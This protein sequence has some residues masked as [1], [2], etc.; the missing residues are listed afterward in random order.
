MAAGVMLCF[1]STAWGPILA[2]LFFGF[3][4]CM[5]TVAPPVMVVKEFGKKDLGMVVGIV[6]AFEM[7]GAATGNV[8]SGV[9]FDTYLSFIPVWISVIVA[10]ALMGLTLI[11][12][13]GGARRLVARC[14]EQGAAALDAEGNEI[15]A[16]GGPVESAGA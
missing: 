11:A 1:A 7:L 4:T 15:P 12:S 13:I 9:L 8:V 3:A 16:T 6:T 10:S 14:I 2:S 5:G